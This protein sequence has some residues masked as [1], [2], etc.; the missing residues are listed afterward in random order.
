MVEPRS[1]S[2]PQDRTIVLPLSIRSNPTFKQ[3][4]ASVMFNFKEQCNLHCRTH[5]PRGNEHE[6]T[7]WQIIYSY[8]VTIGIEKASAQSNTMIKKIVVF[9]NYHNVLPAYL[10]IDYI[11]Q[12]PEAL[13]ACIR[14][15]KIKKT[16]SVFYYLSLTKCKWNNGGLKEEWYSNFRFL[17][18]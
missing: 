15:R 3:W 5:T 11:L 2:V 9:N 12:I 18:F 1:C 6:P 16:P 17:K 14:S 7:N 4:R 8:K 13:F 10:F